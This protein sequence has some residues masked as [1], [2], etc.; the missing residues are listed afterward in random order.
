M[1]PAVKTVASKGVLKM[2]QRKLS[3]VPLFL[4]GLVL[5]NS[6]MALSLEDMQGEW[7]LVSRACSNGRAPDDAFKLGRDSTVFTL[8]GSSAVI[9]QVIA[10]RTY[11]NIGTLVA[12]ADQW[13]YTG[14]DGRAEKLRAELDRFG[15][16]TIYSD[17][18]GP[19]GTCAVG[20]E[21]ATYL[22]RRDTG[23]AK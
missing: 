20:S 14:S 12:K 3:K 21:L 13:T 22:V 18:F 16:L 1:T 9:H 10:G 23:G 6:A 7:E 17:S 11:Y 19:G 5:V 8:T 4:V 15:I 2:M